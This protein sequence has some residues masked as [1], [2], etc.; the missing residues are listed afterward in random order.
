[1]PRVHQPDLFGAETEPAPVK[2]YAPSIATVRAEVTKI[3]DTAR[4]AK[5][6][7]WTP[8][9]VAFWKTVFPQMVNW[10]PA[11]EAAQLRAA[12]LEEISRLEETARSEPT[13]AA[14][15]AKRRRKAGEG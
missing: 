6:M 4:I 3:L 5:D 9:E 1:M 10:L 8:K 12:F 14:S 2:S 11:E 7:P 15:G 13:H